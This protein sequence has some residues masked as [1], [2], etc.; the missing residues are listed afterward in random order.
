MVSSSAFLKS[1]GFL[2]RYS[3]GIVLTFLLAFM[4]RLF[5]ISSLQVPN[6]HMAPTLLPG[7]YVV[8][9]RLPFGL[10]IPIAG[11][12]V[13]RG[14]PERG[15]LV[16]FPC[17]ANKRKS[18]VS[19]V[20]G[21]PGDRLEIQ[22]E[23]LILNGEMAEYESPRV[24]ASGLILRERVLGID[25]EIAIS[26][27]EENSRFGPII[28]GP[29]KA[30]MLSDHRDLARDSRAYGTVPLTELEAR[31]SMVWISWSWPDESS[32]SMPSLRWGRLFEQV[33]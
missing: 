3:E 1:I 8:A 25:H 6:N 26:G 23:R 16:L 17:P 12:K 31:I 29:G 15:D 2:R 7:D 11:T 28:V 20:M 30:F 13:G 27:Q 14:R 32:S 10:K 9:Y 5:V 18:C 4:V 22:G 24:H 19:R 33:K 21:V